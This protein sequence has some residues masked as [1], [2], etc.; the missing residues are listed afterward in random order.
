MVKC[1]FVILSPLVHPS[2]DISTLVET[3]MCLLCGAAKPQIMF[4]NS[5]GSFGNPWKVVG[6]T[7]SVEVTAR[8]GFAMMGT[9]VDITCEGVVLDA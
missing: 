6:V 9:M 2:C 4:R 1:E 5:G 7:A 8:F 3:V